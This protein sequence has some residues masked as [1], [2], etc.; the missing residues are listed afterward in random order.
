[1]L[2]RLNVDPSLLKSVEVLRGPASLLYGSGALAGVVSLTTTDADDLL[3]DGRNM[4][5]RLR[6]GYQD[7]YQ[8]ENLG[9]ALFGRIGAFDIL[10]D[11]NARST[12][13][14][15]QGGGGIMPLSATDNEG[16][17]LKIGWFPG[18]A[19]QARLSTTGYRTDSVSPGNPQQPLTETSIPRD[20]Q[21]RQRFTGLNY[22]FEP[23]WGG[24]FRDLTV[25][26]NQ[27]D[28]SS[29][30]AQVLAATAG[31]LPDDANLPPGSIDAINDALAQGMNAG[32]EPEPPP[33]PSVFELTSRG[34]NVLAGLELPWWRGR[35]TIGADWAS[36]VGR[37]R[38]GSDPINNFPDAEQTVMGV[39]VQQELDLLD[40][41]GIVGGVRYDQYENVPA[42]F[43]NATPIKEDAVSMQLG[44]TFALNGVLGRWLG[45]GWGEGLSIS[46]LYGEAFRAPSLREAYSFGTHFLGN[47]FVINQNLRPEKAAN[48]ELTLR[49]APAG[50]LGVMDRFNLTLTGYQNDIEDFM[51]LIVTVEVEGPFPPAPQCVSPAPPQGCINHDNPMA[52]PI[53]I[54]GDT[55]TINLP[56]ATLR[57]LEFEID[58]A[59]GWLETGLKAAMVRG[60][61]SETGNP[62]SAIPADTVSL[63]IGGRLSGG[64]FSGL[65]SGLNV[66]H[67]LDQNR[68]PPPAED[69]IAISTPSEG[70]T[71]FN[72]RTLWSPNRGWLKGANLALAVDNLTDERYRNHLT[73][74][75]QH[76]EVGRNV[77]ASIA[78]PF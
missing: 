6:L 4:G 75:E 77:K 14:F 76:F 72:W 38:E 46:A 70:Y 22:S 20:R 26:L 65:Y 62:L 28:Y 11:F 13:D 35:M 54:G 12:D 25:Q 15:R 64:F 37:A 39:F 21:S 31:T 71:V 66:A 33:P 9:A 2:S 78:M 41:L 69:R 59:M 53:F 52:P 48:K 30:E 61:D 45:D 60:T 10:G 47:E 55:T 1:M 56:S 68:I 32:E 16:D 3:Q 67:T 24:I 43:I 51:E 36:D 5:A 17:L 58:S 57:G 8:G 49:Y 73:F 50:G 40:N 23:G 29:T 44:G 42:S 63:D 74:D 34:G 27:S 19:H 18:N 7:A